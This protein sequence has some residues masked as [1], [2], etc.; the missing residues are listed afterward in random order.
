MPILPGQSNRL[1][2]VL[3]ALGKQMIAYP[4]FVP[5]LGTAG[6]TQ[7]PLLSIA[8]DVMQRILSEPMDW[9]WNR[10]QI[11]SILTV[12]LQQDYVTQITD[13]GWI[14][15]GIVVDINNSTNNGNLAPKPQFLLNAVRDQQTSSYQGRP[16]N[17]N[18]IPN[19]LAVMGQW[20][21][22]T[23][24][25]CGYGVAQIPITPIQQFLDQNGN[26]LYI[27]STVLG[28][29]INS[30]GF[31]GDPI[32]L[33]FNSPYGVSGATEPLAPADATPGQK[34]QDGTVIWTV[35]D[36]NGYAIRMN[37]IPAFSSL[38]WLA[39]IYY[40]ITPPILTSLQDRISPI[41]P[42][43]SYLFKQ[44][45]RAM[46][47]EHAGNKNAAEA[48]AKWEEDLTVAVRSA[49]R[50]PDSY[51]MVCDQGLMGNSVGQGLTPGLGWGGI[52]LGPG[53]PYN[54]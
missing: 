7:E 17:V 4:E 39:Q 52:N 16:F 51:M 32:T 10:K 12:A 21:A 50:Q 8:N 29:N 37:P 43:M 6:L 22:D 23:A 45:L 41:P 34:I 2:P 9:V 36:P 20:F 47:Y 3:M 33:P 53:N 19:S 35:A 5:V 46:L 13:I 42:E 11:P 24:Y 38:A 28:L 54:W 49:D 26:I 1:S 27:D 14:E 18:F 31:N 15:N 44:G 40:Q 25:G 30:P 48:Y